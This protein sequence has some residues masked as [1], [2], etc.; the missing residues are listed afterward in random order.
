MGRGISEQ[1]AAFKLYLEP[2][3]TCR[4]AGCGVGKKVFTLTPAVFG[5]EKGKP[6]VALNRD[7]RVAL[8]SGIFQKG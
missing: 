5:H 1:Q 2:S 8:E 6:G 3:R 7:H 4:W